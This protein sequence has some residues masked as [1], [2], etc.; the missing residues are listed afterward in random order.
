MN[1]KDVPV[2]DLDLYYRESNQPDYLKT[3]DAK[4]RYRKYRLSYGGTPMDLTG[5]T[6][7]CYMLKAD[8]KSVYIDAEIEGNVVTVCFTNQALA[9]PGVL[10]V[11]IVLYGSDN[12][13][14]SSFIMEY[15][16]IKSLRN[17]DT[18]ESSDDF[19]AIIS[20]IKKVDE[21][22]AK[23][24]LIQAREVLREA[25][26]AKRESNEDTRI[27]DELT[28]ANA[29]T[30]RGNNESTR[31]ANEDTRIANENTRKSDEVIRTQSENSRKESESQRQ[32]NESNRQSQE[33][34]RA[35]E[36]AKIKSDFNSLAPEQATNAEV[37][38]ARTDVSGKEHASLKDRL[39]ADAK[40]RDVVTET[41][42]GNF[43]SFNGTVPSPITNVIVKGNT[44]QNPNNLVEIVSSGIDNGDGTWT[45]E[46]VA[47]G[48]NLFNSRL[49]KGD[50]DNVTGLDRNTT[51]HTIT[52]GFIRCMDNCKIAMS[53]TPIVNNAWQAVFCYDR[54]KNFIGYIDGGKVVTTKPN[55]AYIRVKI[56][57]N[58]NSD[59][60]DFKIQ[61]GG[62]A[63]PYT[64]YQETRCDIKLPCQLEKWDRLYF[65]KEENAWCAE[66]GTLKYYPNISKIYNYTDLGNNIRVSHN[67]SDNLVSP[68]SNNCICN[69]LPFDSQLG[70]DKDTEG[71]YILTNKVVVWKIN[72]NKLSELTLEGAKKFIQDTGLY[73]LYPTTNPQKIVLPQS[74]QIKLNAFDT[75][76][77]IYVAS[78]ATDATI[79]ATVSK[80]HSS[81]TI[82]NTKEIERINN[83]LQSVID[84][85]DDVEY[86]Y[87]ADNGVIL[88]KDTNRGNISKVS[89]SGKSLIN[90]ADFSKV[91][92]Q[93]G[94]IKGV[95]GK[96]NLPVT[97]AS[98]YYEGDI[99]GQLCTAIFI[100]DNNEKYTI[101]TIGKDT[102]NRDAW[103]NQVG[104]QVKVLNNSEICKVRC[105][106][107]SAN[108]NA[109]QCYI[110]QGDVSSNIP[111]Y[112][113][114]VASVSNES[115]L[116]LLTRKE[117]GNLFDGILDE[118]MIATGNGLHVSGGND[119]VSTKNR[120]RI[121][122]MTKAYRVKVVDSKVGARLDCVFFYDIY[123][124]YL[125]FQTT[126]ESFT[127]P[128]KNTAYVEFRILRPGSKI[129]P[130]ELVS[131][132]LIIDGVQDYNM[133]LQS[134]S[135]PIMYKDDTGEWVS[136]TE[137]RGVEL[138]CDRIGDDKYLV[139]TDTLTLDGEGDYR[140]SNG[141]G[142]QTNTIMVGIY[143]I[144]FR[145]P[146]DDKLSSHFV[147]ANASKLGGSTT[148]NDD[149][150]GVALA[151]NGVI[152]VRLS[153]TKATDLASAKEY[154]K[155][156]PI[157]LVFLRPLPLEYAV[158]ELNV[159]VFRGDTLVTTNATN[160]QP[161]LDITI[162]SSI[163]S[164]IGNMDDTLDNAVDDIQELKH[165]VAKLTSSKE[166]E[167]SGEGYKVMNETEQGTLS[168]LTIYGKSL[169]NYGEPSNIYE[170]TS[171]RLV[172]KLKNKDILTNNEITF[173]NFSDKMM[174]LIIFD[175]VTNSY[176]KAID[177]KVGVTKVYISNTEKI[178]NVIGLYSNGWKISDKDTIRS[179]YVMLIGDHA[180][181]P[182]N[183]YFEGIASVGSGNE[184]EVLSRKEDGNLFDGELSDGLYNTS[185]GVFTPNSDVKC[186]KNKIAIFDNR[187]IK[188][189]QPLTGGSY[190]VFYYDNNGNYIESQ[191]IT[192]P[193]V[194]T[195]NVNAR[196]INFQIANTHYKEG[197]TLN[198]DGFNSSVYK[199]DK[200][201]ILFKDTD[202][203]W[204]PVTELRG[205]DLYKRD[206][207]E[208][209]SDGKHY[210]HVRTIPISLNNSNEW[211][212]FD[213]VKYSQFYI[214]LSNDLA[215][216][217]KEAIN[218][219]SDKY[220]SCRYWDR[221][222]DGFLGSCFAS[223]T[224]LAILKP[225]GTSVESF[226]SEISNG[227]NFI[228][229]LAQE[230]VYEVNPILPQVF[231]DATMLQ[232]LGGA[233]SAEF[234]AKCVAS[235]SRR[236][237][238]IESRLDRVE[239][240]VFKAVDVV[241]AMA[242]AT[243]LRSI[244][245]S[246]NVEHTQRAQDTMLMESDMR[247]MS[248]E[249]L[250][251]S[252][253]P[254][255][256]DI[257]YV[258][259]DAKGGATIMSASYYNFIA[260]CIA[261]KTQSPEYL[262]NYMNLCLQTGRLDQ[263]EF[264][265]LHAMLYPTTTEQSTK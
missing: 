125:G 154:I 87:K 144:P 92:V 149:V 111:P 12:S 239:D 42:E 230:K 258:M 21:L 3:D 265:K 191:L 94:A 244:D 122:D 227:V 261:N 248:M 161:D 146:I 81:A 31:M 132:S 211:L 106:S 213:T 24:E 187:K 199:Q 80:T 40:M 197:I 171:D 83:Q 68:S 38:L 121:C 57:K 220:N 198:Y 97:N 204:K 254:V 5:V 250:V 7:R 47:C 34:V 195:P 172:V 137:L 247:L 79:Q 162:T 135:Q 115:G 29:E 133:S 158:N 82:E 253:K 246:N 202:G 55:T 89:I 140:L 4:G 229:Q 73:M 86:T 84:N 210:L 209:H 184:I 76:T 176:K 142:T 257:K 20:T 70:W 169:V 120:V 252:A 98:F 134:D 214:Q 9:C 249:L 23:E 264:D 217:N 65:D 241:S 228:Y 59:I 53:F 139:A 48:E 177:V 93:G 155:N 19:S 231:D 182:P 77:T 216:D 1:L 78:G 138:D 113:E 151:Q 157:P 90:L 206:T 71:C 22:Q 66:K 186:N 170:T 168:D 136:V 16:V 45:Y 39:D 72:K 100:P 160:V 164:L 110:V 223:N 56:E 141:I 119:Y 8:G 260:M 224:I 116:S 61:L 167:F 262:E 156:N 62:V 215:I 174:N 233:L 245:L 131:V 219:I 183:G 179:K 163:N 26:E 263:D 189:S 6:A 236:I 128:Y 126:T 159:D 181:N 196:Y 175:S 43:I 153:K 129:Y 243:D 51:T 194:F 178:D 112:F 251:N 235:Y 107:N 95:G 188:L 222:R 147:C 10:K 88:A 102:V 41:K 104:I 145:K 69:V 54:D 124:S 237:E 44:Y 152:Y 108:A 190:R 240:S 74:E 180:Q 207:I 14:I 46:I 75:S 18:L 256:T 13:E 212:K 201:P 232:I 2:I 218:V 96:I 33:Q 15:V 50:I 166:Y 58:E 25:N 255:S 173:V 118:S 11:E 205:I 225:L 117:D 185:T 37:Q 200:K 226:K 85:K 114:G 203:A 109:I 165:D 63:T 143:G 91:V 35:N 234:K 27:A 221:D 49:I 150:E 259:Y 208:Q 105:Y 192:S 17:P 242:M 30:T 193:Y 123:G 32:S 28:R 130:S 101:H 67:Q 99:F 36:F 127:I 52:E 238:S 148:W 103:F 64:P 60:S